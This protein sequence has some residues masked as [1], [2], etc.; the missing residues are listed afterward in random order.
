MTNMMSYLV[1]LFFPTV[2][3]GETLTMTVNISF[4]IQNN[5]LYLGKGSPVIRL[6][7]L[8]KGE[9]GTCYNETSGCKEKYD[10][11]HSGDKTI[12]ITIKEVTKSKEGFYGLYLYCVGLNHHGTTEQ[13]LKSFMLITV[14]KVRWLT[15][16]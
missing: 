1:I 13:L 3:L 9:D 6:I 4:K 10:L 15:L 11:R 7:K 16:I 2:P 5:Y 8:R 12:N 14:G